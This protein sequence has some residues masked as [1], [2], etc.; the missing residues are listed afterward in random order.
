MR[1]V[2]RDEVLET[3]KTVRGP[4]FERD[5][6]AL[7]MV[8]DV[9]ISDGKVYF[10]ITVPAERADELEPLRQ[11]AERAVKAMPG[12]KGALVSLTAE[13]KA[14]AAPAARPQPAAHG[15]AHSHAQAQAPSG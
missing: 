14:G 9:F 12:V 10:S 7:G 8:S 13:R 6:V 3:L 4:G 2:T 11:A 15:H 1:A 5:V